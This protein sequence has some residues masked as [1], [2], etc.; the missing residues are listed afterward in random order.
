[1]FILL[2]L[3]TAMNDPPADHPPTWSSPTTLIVAIA[4]FAFLIAATVLSGTIE[5]LAVIAATAFCAL[6]AALRRLIIILLALLLVLAM[7][8]AGRH[9]TARSDNVPPPTYAASRWEKGSDDVNITP[10]RDT[11]ARGTARAPWPG[12]ETSRGDTRQSALMLQVLSGVLLVCLGLLLGATWTTQ[13]LRPKLDRQAEE[14]RR[15][16]AEWLA[17]RTARKQR[18]TCPR[19][20]SPLTER[21]WYITPTVV[22][23]PRDDD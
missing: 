3:A 10:E 18:G 11:V 13:A 19:C 7:V 5:A 21:N 23:D 9:H 4:V 22:D 14:R 17:V 20:G 8:I 16:N 6:I 12:S 2:T 15:L 1:M